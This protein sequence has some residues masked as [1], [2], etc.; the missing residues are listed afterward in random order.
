M[1]LKTTREASFTLFETVIALLI[2]SV[3]ILQMTSLQGNTIYFSEYGSN[4]V[5][6]TWLAKRVISQVEYYWKTKAYSELKNEGRDE[7]PFEDNPDF[8]YRLEIRDW[9]FPLDEFIKS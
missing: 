5:R 8:K 3:M 4:S 1:K 7:I 6:A 9:D 2:M